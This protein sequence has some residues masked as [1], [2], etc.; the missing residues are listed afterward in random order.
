MIRRQVRPLHEGAIDIFRGFGTFLVRA[1][2]F[3]VTWRM[4]HGPMQYYYAYEGALR[5]ADVDGSGRDAL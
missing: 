3:N 2:C 5:H 4:E 1:D